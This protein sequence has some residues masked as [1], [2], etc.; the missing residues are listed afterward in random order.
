MA[1]A[2]LN[3][4]GIALQTKVPSVLACDGSALDF[5]ERKGWRKSDQ[6]GG[7]GWLLHYAMKGGIDLGTKLP[8]VL[9][10]VQHWTL[11]KERDGK[12]QIE[13]GE[14]MAFALCNEGGID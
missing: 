1:F 11:V 9:V 14:W 4:G 10:T 8:S 13:G 3:E 2:Q 6:R 12:S 7:N 5:S